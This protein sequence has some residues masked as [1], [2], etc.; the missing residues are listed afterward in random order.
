MKLWKEG[1]RFF[2]CL[3]KSK[4][5]HFGSITIRKKDSKLFAKNQGSKA[6]K[7]FL[8][9]WGISIRT[10]K[11]FYLKSENFHNNILTN[12]NKNL[13]YFLSL[14][15]DKVSFTYYKILRLFKKE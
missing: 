15:K 3:G 1:V 12:P 6:N 2:Q 4:V 13:E 10:F 7:I 5:Y 11:K 8:L 14:L 9:K